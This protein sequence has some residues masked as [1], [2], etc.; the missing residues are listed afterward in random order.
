MEKVIVESPYAGNVAENLKYARL[1][2]VDC[3]KRGEA[4][5]ASHLLY[6][7]VLDDTVVEERDLGIRAGLAWSGPDV[8]HVFYVDNGIS[9]GM[10]LAA[11]RCYIYELRSLHTPVPKVLMSK[12]DLD[13]FESL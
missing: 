1:C 11:K 10:K 2:M 7:Q 6:T 4:P 8:K 5:L 9:A 3:L 12:T 13:F